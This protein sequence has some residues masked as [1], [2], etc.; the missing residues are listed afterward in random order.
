MDFNSLKSLPFGL[1]FQHLFK[2]Q[3]LEKQLRFCHTIKRC[4]DITVMNIYFISSTTAEKITYK[5]M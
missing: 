5:M 2:G 1:V 4:T 3:F